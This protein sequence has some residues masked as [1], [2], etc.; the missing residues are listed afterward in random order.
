MN[1]LKAHISYLEKK[2]LKAMNLLRV[3]S[4][5]DWGADS[6]T[7]FKLYHSLIRSELDYGCIIYGSARESYLHTLDCVQNV[8]IRLCLVA[9]R[10]S[11]TF[12]LHVEANELPLQLRRQMLALQ[13]IAELKSNPNNPA[14]TSVFQPNV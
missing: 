4:H 12:S 2:C 6:S 10:T 14:Y 8:A 11:P 5:T 9:F 7:L 3:V 13:Y 1:N